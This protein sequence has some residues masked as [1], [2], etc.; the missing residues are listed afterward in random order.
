MP[1]QVL[2]QPGVSGGSVEDSGGAQNSPP[3]PHT[4]VTP[5]ITVTPQVS[6]GGL[7]G[8]SSSAATNNSPQTPS[9]QSSQHPPLKYIAG[10]LDFGVKFRKGGTTD[11]SLVGSL[12]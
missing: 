2:Q 9:T 3:S 8:S 11:Y 7:Q 4:P 5:Q 1:G 10:T 6:Q 12:P